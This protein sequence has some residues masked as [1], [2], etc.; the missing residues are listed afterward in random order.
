MDL[1]RRR[2]ELVR[3]NMNI[4]NLY[5][6]A[7]SG[8][9]KKSRLFAKVKHFWKCIKWSKQRITICN[10]LNNCIMNTTHAAFH[11]EN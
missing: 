2:K 1:R 3:D 4:W 8:L 11:L 7:M 9:G 10:V 6:F 5:D